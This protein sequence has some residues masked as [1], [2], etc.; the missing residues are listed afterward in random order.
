MAHFSSLCDY[1]QEKRRRRRRTEPMFFE[2]ETASVW[3]MRNKPRAQS[4]ASIKLST[5]QN[6]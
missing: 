2:V 5:F 1:E 6:S 3:E 4:G